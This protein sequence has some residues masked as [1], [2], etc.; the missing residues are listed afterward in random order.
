VDEVEVFYHISGIYVPG[1][2]TGVRFDDPKLG[3]D[4]PLPVT[5]INDRDR[6]WPLLP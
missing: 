2:L 1:K 3:I 4:W 5:A 6:N